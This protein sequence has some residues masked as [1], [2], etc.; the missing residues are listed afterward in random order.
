MTTRRELAQG[1]RRR[2][3]PRSLRLIR[4]RSSLLTASPYLPRSAMPG[5]RKPGYLPCRGGQALA[6]R[7]S[8]DEGLV[9]SDDFE[10]SLTAAQLNPSGQALAALL[11]TRV[12]D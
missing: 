4:L 2:Q 9:L 3:Q 10:R 11:L 7:R 5:K 1:A 6:F 8:R 12:S